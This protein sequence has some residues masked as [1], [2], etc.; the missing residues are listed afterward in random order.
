MQEDKK[1]KKEKG[2]SFLE[3]VREIDEKEKRMEEEAEEK[4]RQILAE[5]QKKEREEYDKRIRQERIELMRLK[6]GV[7]TESEMIP[8]KDDEA[9]K[10]SFWKKIGNFFYHSKWWLVITVFI[11]SVFTYMIVDYITTVRPDMIVMVLTDDLTL[12]SSNDYLSNYFEQY[13]DDV[14]EDGEISVD[15]YRIPID[16]DISNAEYYTGNMTKLSSQFQLADSI[17][18]ITD[19][20]AN[21]KILAEETLV[22]LEELSRIIKM[23]GVLAFI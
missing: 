16:N 15:I 10:L 3:T 6:Q 2:K 11:V 8:T 1:N 5:K 23:S 22:N 20:V 21:E 9:P 13:V 17:M 12:Q 19:A 7:I 18:V 14:N 4:R